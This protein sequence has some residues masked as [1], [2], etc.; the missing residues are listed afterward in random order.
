M[1]PILLKMAHPHAD[2]SAQ[3]QLSMETGVREPF[4]RQGVSS[5]PLRHPRGARE[6][7]QLLV[8]YTLAGVLIAKSSEAISSSIELAT[9]SLCLKAAVGCTARHNG[10][11]VA[12]VWGLRACY[13]QGDAK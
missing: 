6:H 5:F 11:F 4:K 12:N 3:I 9:A 1:D 10:Q 7:H 13:Q 8:P 2:S